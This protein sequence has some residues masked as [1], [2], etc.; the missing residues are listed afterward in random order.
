MRFFTLTIFSLLIT[1]SGAVAQTLQ[2]Q[3]RQKYLIDSIEV[4]GLKVSIHKL[5]SLIVD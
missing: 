5:S 2:L 1:T 3:K 4:T